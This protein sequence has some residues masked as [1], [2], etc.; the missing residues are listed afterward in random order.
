MQVRGVILV[1]IALFL[2]I[3]V[4]VIHLLAMCSPH[5]K[6]TK[7]DRA[8]AMEPVS[9]G[10]WERCEHFNITVVKQG[11]TLGT[12]QRVQICWPNRYMRYSPDK[13]HTCHNFRRQCPVMNKDQLPEG[14]SCHYLPSA[15]A[16]QWLTVL[17]AVFLILGL[18]LLYL[19]TIA[20]PQNDSALI[21]LGYGPFICFL[22]AL[23][24]MSTGLILL[25][26]YLRRD[27]YEDFS[28]PLESISNVTKRLESFDLHSLRN[29]AKYQEATVS[30]ELYNKAKNELINDANTHYHTAI[31]RGT[32]YEII[33]TGL[34][35]V[36]TALAFWLASVSRSE[37]I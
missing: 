12:R 25:G 24:L 31:G 2:G 8:P 23:L 5:W 21:V 4:F 22:L 37:D 27:T 10:L 1:T 16:L 14:C 29:F 3:S 17:A 15:K 11:V 36:V 19:K 30:R 34:V 9:Y 13:Y 32:I 7:R 18:L 33:A 28:F 6:I 35:F 26:A 20:S